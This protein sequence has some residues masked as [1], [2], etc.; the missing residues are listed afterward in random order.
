MKN[1]CMKGVIGG[2]SDLDIVSMTILL[3]ASPYNPCG[4]LVGL[5]ATLSTLRHPAFLGLREDKKGRDV[6]IDSAVGTALEHD[7]E[8]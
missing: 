8:K 1:H 7:P 3:F 6:V 5:L 2:I 4:K